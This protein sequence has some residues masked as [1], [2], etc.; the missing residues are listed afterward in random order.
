MI[1]AAEFLKWCA[2]FGIQI[3]GGGSGATATE[4]QQS[5]FNTGPDSGSADNYVVTLTPAPLSLTD[6]L[7]VFFTPA[8]DNLTNAPVINLNGLGNVAIGGPAPGLELFP[9]DINTQQPCFL[10]YSSAAGQ[11]SLINPYRFYQYSEQFNNYVFGTGG[12]AANIYTCALVPAGAD[13][14]LPLTDGFTFA[15]SFADDNTGAS[16]IQINSSGNA[17]PILTTALSALAGGEIIANGIY[18]FTFNSNA[19]GSASFII[20]NASTVASMGVTAAQVQHSSFNIGPDSGA[21]DAYAV[22]LTPPATSYT[23]GMLIQ[24]TPANVNL[25]NEPT[26]NVDGLGPIGIIPPVLAATLYPGDLTPTDIAFLVYSQVSGAFILLNPSSWNGYNQQFNQLTYSSD[27]G[28]ANAYNAAFLLPGKADIDFP[29][30]DGFKV[31][32][33]AGNNNTGPSTMQ[34]NSSGIAT[35]ILTSNLQPLI[36]GEILLGSVYELIYQASQTS[37]ILQNP[38]AGGNYISSVIPI[39]SEVALTTDTSASITSITLTP[40][41]WNLWAELWTDASAGTTTTQIQASISLTDNT[42]AT[43]PSDSEST[44]LLAVAGGAAQSFHLPI[45]GTRVTVTSTTTV[46]LVANVSF[47]VSTLFG[48]GKICASLV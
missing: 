30:T 31:L 17:Y 25:T 19:P 24:F 28:I 13:V 20:N 14:N 3:G 40:G 36:G 18:F 29:V 46:Y 35:P 4:V 33:N 43:V 48:Y 6:N 10:L 8:F 11:F 16:T 5:Q 27:A 38:S 37:W 23:D 1:T 47:A 22:T 41:K 26:L 21:A 44:T 39:G 34:V 2:V 15:A 32:L 45:A 12:G 7:I 9:G 42:I